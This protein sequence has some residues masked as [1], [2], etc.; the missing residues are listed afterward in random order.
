MIA[1]PDEQHVVWLDG[2]YRPWRDAR[3][4]LTA[5]HYGFGVFEGV[6]A[7]STA[8][9]TAL[10]RLTEHTARLFRSAKIL[11]M[12]LAERWAPAQLDD[13]QCELLR[14]N[15]LRD[16]YVRPFVFYDG[17]LGMRPSV[18]G[19]RLR[20]AVLALA[21]GSRA[22]PLRGL[23]LRCGA[24]TRAGSNAMLFKA[25]ANANYLS[26]MLALQDAQAAGADDVLLLDAGGYAT[27]ASG[28]NI[29]AVRRGQLLTPMLESVLEGIT[30]DTVLQLAAEAG[31]TAS[32][33]RL[34][35]EDLYTA[36]ELFLTGTASEI[37]P[38]VELDGRR[39]GCGETGEVTAQLRAAYAAEVTGKGRHVDWLQHIG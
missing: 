25:K 37:A 11:G 2:E 34:T 5:H 20:V 14:R 33:A 27:E 32:A 30:R 19:L 38:V 26:S 8:A 29:F 6:R 18:E 15:E 9:G 39:I 12:P 1:E 13:V 21:W 35:R 7:Y 36:D 17:I 23:R 22:K 24:L 16:A 28:A 4:P 10:F 3:L 31:I